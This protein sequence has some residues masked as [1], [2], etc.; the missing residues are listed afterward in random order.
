MC[1][2]NLNILI[3]NILSLDLYPKILRILFFILNELKFYH[4]YVNNQL[5]QSL[6]Q[7]DIQHNNAIHNYNT[8]NQNDLHLIRVKHE[9]ARNC[10]SV[11]IPKTINSV[12]D[13]VKNKVITHSL[14]SYAVYA[15]KYLI[16]KYKMECDIAE[17]YICNRN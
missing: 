13:N 3:L 9:Y 6:Q 2:I 4:K 8:R 14:Q 10:V 1:Y 5:P 17:C 11:S 15:K 12:P 7:F 16:D